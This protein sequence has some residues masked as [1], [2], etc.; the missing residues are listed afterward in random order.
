MSFLITFVITVVA[1]FVLRNPL[2][3]FPVVFYA[4]SVALVAFYF[5]LPMLELPR[6][7]MLATM[8]TMGRCF[9]P[10]AMFVVVMYIGVLPYTSRARRWL[11]PVRGPLSIMAC[12]LVLGH[13]VG[14][15]MSYMPR[16]FGSVAVSG[17]VLASFVVA[18]VLFVL[19]L[20][21]GVT[22]FE[23]VKRR[24]NAR[25]W[26]RVQRLAYVFYALVYVHLMLMLLPSALS[27]GESAAFGM[28]VY[29][30]VFGAYAV[31]RVFVAVRGL[32]TTLDTAESEVAGDADLG[33]ARK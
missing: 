32:G 30:V 33:P 25:T 1:C 6:A 19:L 17:N 21:L 26:K 14:Y 8:F 28:V 12:I 13:M 2:R 20:V 15:M 3:K 31:A 10:V 9:V 23:F 5:A 7:V 22:S 4:L 24:M 11:Q 18:M 27:G 29:T 16:V